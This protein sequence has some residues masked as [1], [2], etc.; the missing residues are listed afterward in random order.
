MARFK[1]TGTLI[2][3]KTFELH[4]NASPFDACLING[5]NRSNKF[6]YPR[7]KS[8]F[9]YFPAKKDPCI[10]VKREAKSNHC[11]DGQELIGQEIIW[12]CDV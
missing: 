9:M 1:G 11:H 3:L 10:K 8:P 7:R 4:Q 6:L 2:Q 5:L 12:Q